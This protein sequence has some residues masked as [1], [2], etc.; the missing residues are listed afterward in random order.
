MKELL[1]EKLYNLSRLTI[2]KTGYPLYI[3][4]GFVRN[5]FIC[6]IAEGDIDLAAPVP[7]ETF[8]A[9][10]EEAGYSVAA[11]Y[12]RTGTAV[13]VSEGEKYEYTAFR[14]EIYERGGRHSPAFTEPTFDLEEDARRR[15]F[16]CNA[17]YY[18]IYNGVLT[19][20]LGGINDIKAKVLNTVKE[21][22]KVFESDGLRLMRLARF[23]GEL[24]FSAGNEALAAANRYADNIKDVSPERIFDELKKILKSDKKYGFSDKEGHYTGLKV[25]SEI[26]VLDRLLPELTAGRGMAQ[27]A[28]YHKHD[29]LEHSL[30]TVFYAE[31][32]I[33][34]AALFHDV[35]KPYCKIN[36]GE[37]YGHAEV[38]EKMT[39]RI[40][41]AWKADKKTIKETAFLVG[42]HMLDLDCGESERKVRAF[43]AENYPLVPKLLALKQADYS[44]SK[45]DGVVSP[46]VEKWRAILKKMQSDGTPFTLKDLKITAAELMEEGFC[47]EDIGKELNKLLSVCREFPERNE[48]NY[49]LQKSKKDFGKG[50]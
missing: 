1:S 47:G 33:R 46:T 44:A 7:A 21:P 37:Y 19:D 14:K 5:F 34:L 8:A 23:C 29:V 30:K 35:A 12:K 22:E 49:L 3:V 25:L 18:D 6:G 26:R 38:G 48:K 39:K 20:V 28:D 43:I 15:D 4:G 11:V 27:R 24:G 36:Y 2:R 10:A 16:K 45:E 50:R 31:K 32:D 17:V 40:L 42:A 13:I 41:T 9:L